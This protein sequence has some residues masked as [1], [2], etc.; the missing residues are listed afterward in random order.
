MTGCDCWGHRKES[1]LEYTSGPHE[2]N[3]IKCK[4]AKLHPNILQVMER[5]SQ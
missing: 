3:R 5:E 1:L 4:R 2:T